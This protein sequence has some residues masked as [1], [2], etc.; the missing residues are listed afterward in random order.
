[1]VRTETSIDDSGVR[2]ETGEQ[3]RTAHL[4][5]PVVKAPSLEPLRADARAGTPRLPHPVLVVDDVGYLTYGT[6]AA[7]LLFRSSDTVGTAQ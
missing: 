4:P 7:N 6:D 2:D 3:C 5:L 1:M